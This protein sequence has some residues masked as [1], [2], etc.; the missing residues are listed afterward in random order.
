MSPVLP[1]FKTSA[2]L[3]AATV[4]CGNGFPALAPGDAGSDGTSD[5]VGVDAVPD[6]PSDT[7]GC[8]TVPPSNI[9]GLAPQCGCGPQAT[10]D[11]DYPTHSDGTTVCV[12]SVGTAGIG[13]TC[14]ATFNCAPGLACWGGVCRPY[15]ST[16][17]LDCGING[18][19]QCEQE[20]NGAQ[21][22]PN[23]TV[24]EINCKLDD[25]YAC[26]GGT[27][28][29]IWVGG[30]QTDCANL[31]AYDQ[32]SC[33]AQ[34]PF[35]APGYSCLQDYSCAPWCEVSLDNCGALQCTPFNT[36]F[37]V[38]GIEYGVCL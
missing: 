6:A 2:F 25:L 14:T 37:V 31:A 30:D 21:A 3:A 38:Q 13:S 35:C 10:C 26:G 19:G 23:A 34:A 9:C 36:P 17:G 5:D 11:V 7:N 12:T 20:Y 33:T 28:G 18:T 24:C 32:F 15:C 1:W 8:K 4:A 22:I 29:C 27:N 16:V